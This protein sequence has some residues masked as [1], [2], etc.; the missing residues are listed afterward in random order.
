MT[1]SDAVLGSAHYIAPETTKGE[2]ATVQIDIYALGIVFYELLCGSVPFKGDNPIQI[3][4]KHLREEIPSIREFN[5]TLPQSIENIIIKATA[6]NRV[7]RYASAKEMMYDLDMC[8]LPEFA[9]VDKVTLT[10]NEKGT[11]TMVLNRVAD[12][13][14][15]TKTMEVTAHRKEKDIS[16]SQKKKDAADHKKKMI[17]IAV[18]AVLCL[19]AIGGGAWWLFG[20]NNEPS[21]EVRY[22]RVPDLKGMT[23]EEA[24]EALAKK[25]LKL[26]TKVEKESTEDVEEGLIIKQSKQKNERVK[27]GSSIK[28]TISSGMYFEIEDYVG[29]KIEE[30]KQKLTAQG[31]EVQVEE[32]ENEDYPAGTIIRQLLLDEGTKLDPGEKA[33]IKFIVAKEKAAETFTLGYYVGL[34][35]RE[36]R[37]LLTAEGI[38]TSFKEVPLTADMLHSNPNLQEGIIISQNYTKGTVFDLS[39]DNIVSF[40]YCGAKVV[41]EPE[42]PTVGE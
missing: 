31:I 39:K 5:P 12:L 25:K 24:K 41:D 33:T 27:Q 26:S 9:D 22:S 30:A 18:V 37:G 6:K 4:M 14:T 19:G 23:L 36:V 20:S 7:C 13:N 40:E 38:K 17:I 15:D 3:A 35:Y 10:T 8:L 29:W 11:G 34:D 21:E 42:T 2:T 28:V 16:S 1:Q 32:E